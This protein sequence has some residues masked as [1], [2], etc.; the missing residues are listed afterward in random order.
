MLQ[1][2]KIFMI[3]NFQSTFSWPHSNWQICLSKGQTNKSW[4][5]HLETLKPELL[6][7]IVMSCNATQRFNNYF[8]TVDKPPFLS[9]FFLIWVVFFYWIFSSL[10]FYVGK[11]RMQDS[12]RYTLQIRLVYNYMIIHQYI[13]TFI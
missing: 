7:E 8:L 6:Y 1:F 13:S 12:V 11:T 3:K 2:L 5:P 9:I 4:V 10:V